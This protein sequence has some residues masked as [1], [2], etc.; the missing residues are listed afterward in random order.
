VFA[1]G[2]FITQS[3]DRSDDEILLG[4][5][6][7]NF[8][9]IDAAVKVAA[10]ADVIVLAIGDTEQTSREGY[11]ATHLGDRSELDIVGEQ[12]A[13]I[14]ALH[15]LGKPI[16]VCA[17]NGR[18]PSWPNIVAK[19]NA[20][21]ECWYPGQEGGTAMAEAL[22]G[23]VN[24]GAKLP[25]TVVRDA[26]QIPYYYNHKPTARRGYLFADKSPLFPFGH[27]LSYTTFEISEPR[28]SSARIN[29]GDSVMVEV[30]V[31]NTGSRAGDE[32]VQLYVHDQVA[33]VTRP[34]KL[35]KEFARVTLEPGE[36]RTVGFSL[37]PDAFRFWNAEMQ[38]VVEPGLFD[39][40]VGA[41]SVDLKTA[42]LE[43]A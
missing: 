29:L 10:S 15:A 16:V 12:N 34:V 41:N 3:D 36:R 7:K 13:L 23:V 30:D 21:L 32:V 22:F 26:G 11:A 4:D 38:E 28:L 17:I 8:K 1:Q 14:D 18:P 43:I 20:I 33:S 2:V 31:K 9:L 40:L 5:P 35:L 39:I 6:G 42:V 19:A 25:L 24:P 27:G 37:G